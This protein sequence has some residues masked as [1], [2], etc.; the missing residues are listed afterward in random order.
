MKTY[1]QRVYLL[2]HGETEWTETKQHTGLTDI[3]LTDEGRLQAEWLTAELK[4]IKLKK[5]FCSPLERARETCEIAGYMPD[6]EIDDDLVEW[7]YGRYEG[8]TTAEIREIEPKWTVFTKGG[9]DGESVGDI[10]TRT[11]RVLSRVR[12]ISGDVALFSSGHFLRALTARWLGLPVS[13]GKYFLLS[14]AS[15]SVL[16]YDRGT[17][18]IMSWNRT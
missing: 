15:V 18:V 1:H 14:T 9:P 4:E 3:P 11:A 17:P 16:S 6:A 8:K 12:A 5:I 2:R 13:Y 7:D 10:A